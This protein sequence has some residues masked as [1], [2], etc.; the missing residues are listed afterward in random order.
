MK[1]TPGYTECLLCTNEFDK[2]K[3]SYKI[4]KIR[5]NG[6]YSSKGHI[7]KTCYTLNEEILNTT[8]VVNLSN[9]TLDIIK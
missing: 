5:K 7:C 8:K 1:P 4:R 9:V 3:D 6:K 2:T